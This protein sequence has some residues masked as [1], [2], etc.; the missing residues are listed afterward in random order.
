M[1]ITTIQKISDLSP[2]NSH[3]NL[4][5]QIVDEEHPKGVPQWFV[6]KQAFNTYDK[7]AVDIYYYPDAKKQGTL[8]ARV[9]SDLKVL[10]LR[11]K[12]RKNLME[13]FQRSREEN[14]DTIISRQAMTIGS[15]PEIFVENGEGK[16]IPAFDFLG[17]KE[18]PTV[19]PYNGD[20]GN[21]T[22]YWDGFQ[23]E[24]TTAAVNCLAWN[25]DSTQIALKTILKAARDHNKS[26]RLSAKTVIDMDLDYLRSLPRKY[27]EFGCM[28]SFNAYGLKGRQQN[29]EDVPFRFAG[30]HIHF[31]LKELKLTDEQ[32]IRIVKTLDAVVGV[33]CVSLFENLD[34]PVR[35]EYYGLPGEYR[36]PPHGLEY[37]TLSNAW[38]FHPAITNLVI[39][40]ARMA[41]SMVL[42]G[43]EKCWKSSEQE[44]IDT[45][46][47][48]DAEHARKI[49]T[50]NEKP[51][52]AL[53]S[54]CYGTAPTNS[55]LVTA[56]LRTLGSP[57][58]NAVAD[59]TNIEA[60]WG[61]NEKWTAHCDGNNKNWHNSYVSISDGR[62]V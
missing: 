9:K 57:V 21:Q 41:V 11:G 40:M 8:H 33:A 55:K 61:L 42:M 18:K 14:L 32:F 5:I 7:Q 51:L 52:R 3:L 30:G 15:D 49:L 1:T 39:D 24:F 48:C 16:L 46:F 43:V 53:I 10:Q 47:T 37:R 22:A 34:N 27:T 62:K 28:P 26:A 58:E 50:R 38:L 59:I 56:T 12:D 23:A 19:V 13:I 2:A 6:L 31:G 17:S 60:N 20:T 35:R 4:P 25:C 45:I 44:V 29:G 36:K 54:R